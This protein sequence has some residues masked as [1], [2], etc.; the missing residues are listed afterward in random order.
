MKPNKVYQSFSL[1]YYWPFFTIWPE[2]LLFLKY[3]EDYSTKF[4]LNKIRFNFARSLR[5]TNNPISGEPL[6]EATP[7]IDKYFK[8]RGTPQAM[9]FWGTVVMLIVFAI[10]IVAKLLLMLCLCLRG[11]KGKGKVAQVGG[12]KPANKME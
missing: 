4:Y 5:M 9:I 11:G 6:Y 10:L 8:M 12:E 3:A 2:K 1:N 7:Y